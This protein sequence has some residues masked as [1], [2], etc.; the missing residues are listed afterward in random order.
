MASDGQL[1]EI[2]L[3]IRVCVC[4]RV[5]KVYQINR[6]IVGQSKKD[7]NVVFT[8]IHGYVCV[9]MSDGP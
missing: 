5:S 9:Y 1:N 6:S 8:Y 7:K 3:F 4:L 2:G